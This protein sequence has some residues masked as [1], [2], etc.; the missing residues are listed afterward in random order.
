MAVLNQ[1]AS[2]RKLAAI[3]SADIAGYSALM[4]ADEEGTVRKL[5]QV[6][7]AVLPVIER[8]GGR[9]IDLA[10]DGILAEFPSAVRAVESAAAVQARMAT[11]NAETGPAMVFR[12]GVNVGDVIDEGERLYGDGVNVA[13]RLQAIAEPGGICISSKVHEEVRDR[14]KLAFRDMGDQELKNIARP[15]RAFSAV[16]AAD[17]RGDRTKWDRGGAPIR[18]ED[19]L[20]DGGRRELRRGGAIIAVEPKV[21]DLLAYLIRHRERVVSRD[22]LIDAVWNGRIVS[23]SALATCINAARVAISDNG[24]AQ[25]L[26]KTLPRK[27]FRFVGAVHEEKASTMDARDAPPTP[28]VSFELPEKPSIA[29]LPFQNLSSDQEQE[30]FADGIVEDIISG[31]SRIRWLF[32]IAR[33]SSFVYKGSA[34]DV[35][36]VG[37]EL[38]V[39]YLLEGSVRRAGDRIRISAQVIEAQSGVHLWAERYDRLYDDIFALQDEI[40]MSVT[41]AIEPSLRK[42]EIERVKRKRP[43]SLDAYDFVLRALPYTYS[44]R[45]EDG[46][47]AAPLLQK[48]LELEP[49]YAAAHASLAWCYHFRFR[50][51]SDEKD[52][53]AAI[54]HA[55]AAIAAGGDDATALGIAGF[56]VSLDERDLVTGLSL[57]DRALAISNSNL[58]ALCCSALILSFAGQF[59]L[60]IE[61]A[62]RALRLSPF[63]SLNYLSN[64]A[65]VV[66]YLC[67]G[68]SAEAH[69]AARASVQLNPRFSVCHLFL[70]AALMALGRREDAKA[71]VRR[72]LELEPTFTSKGFRRIIEFNPAV[73]AL[74]TSAWE[75]AGLPA[76]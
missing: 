69:D 5:R 17:G 66:S 64:N 23:D 76:G 4:S 32:V 15:V 2:A 14:V 19:F 36:Q 40:T 67:T 39:R 72:V 22:E 57:F 51:R 27:G 70:V 33:N 71:E 42:V 55:R 11:L 45:V 37:R 73:V 52:R 59:E 75:A 16:P 25:R 60:A 43:E 20:L 47:I 9:I 10:G 26:I 61:R 18:F 63:D 50:P 12:I 62:Q 34:V 3:L 30:Y 31:L 56:V 46:D 21:F 54:H 58:F 13:A 38:G 6:R 28:T 48:A 8:F 7:E 1:P 68:R 41:G 65:L 53:I 29:V 44:H 35:K 49:N 74:L 24:E